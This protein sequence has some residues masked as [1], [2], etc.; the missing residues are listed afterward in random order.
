MHKYEDGSD[1]ETVVMDAINDLRDVAYGNSA[2]KG[3]HSDP[4][5]ENASTKLMLIV[6]EAAEALECE[7]E[8]MARE[9]LYQ[10]GETGTT[11][12]FRHGDGTLNKPIGY[13]SELA[14]IIIRVADEAG[15]LGIDLGRAVVEKVEYNATRPVKHGKAF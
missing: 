4:A 7:R 10:F 15:R 13:A 8:G 1:R 9:N 12:V 3:F 14:D 5:H 11:N 2:A 6:S